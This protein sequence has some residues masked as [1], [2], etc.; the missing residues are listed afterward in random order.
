MGS[1]KRGEMWDVNVNTARI[2]VKNSIS[3]DSGMQVPSIRSFSANSAPSGK[4]C[5]LIHGLMK[6]KNGGRE[7]SDSKSGHCGHLRPQDIHPHAL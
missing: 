2:E 3:I 4:R 1:Q 7:Q 6:A 5:R